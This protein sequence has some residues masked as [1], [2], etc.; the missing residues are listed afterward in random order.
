MI[1]N[2]FHVDDWEFVSCQDMFTKCAP[3]AFNKPRRFLN[4]SIEY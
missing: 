4:I 1:G 2:S 3:N